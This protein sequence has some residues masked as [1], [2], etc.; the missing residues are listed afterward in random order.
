MLAPDG[1]VVVIARRVVSR[2][3]LTGLDTSHASLAGSDKSKMNPSGRQRNT[4][5][6]AAVEAGKKGAKAL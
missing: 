5:S 3:P 6:M 1:F 2:H 4:R